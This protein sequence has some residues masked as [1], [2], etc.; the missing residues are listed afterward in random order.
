MFDVRRPL[1]QEERR[2]AVAGALLGTAYG[3]ALGLPYE[4]LSQARLQRRPPNLERFSLLGQTGFVSDDTEQAALLTQSVCRA[5]TETGV[6]TERAVQH[7]RRAMVGWFWRLPFGV[8]MGTLR[9]CLKLTFGGKSGVKTAGNGAMMRAAVLGVLVDDPAQRHALGAQLARVTHTDLRAIEGALFVAELA[10]AFARGASGADASAH[11]LSVVEEPSLRAALE[12]VRTRALAGEPAQALPSSGFV[13]HSAPLVL[14]CV[15]RFASA[16]EAVHAAIV[17]GGD[18]DTHAAMV[19]A[20]LGARDGP[21]PFALTERLASGPFSREHLVRLA[22]AAAG[23]SEV[24]K[25]SR[26]VALLR[27]LS[28]YPV[29]LTHGL[30]RLLRVL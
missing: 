2:R 5:R 24:P 29:V 19:G 20:I 6:D 17:A 15:L 8:G 26:L 7:F 9:A 22:N 1:T 18:T 23:A 14:D 11:A 4:G 21:A 16:K 10:A 30:L 3:D 27:N 13:L 25:Y 28:L 12:R